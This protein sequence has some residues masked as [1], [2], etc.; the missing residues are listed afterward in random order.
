MS[1]QPLHHKYR[2]QTFA[3]LVGQE[4]IATTLSNAL[5]N[6]KIAPAYL[7]T[8]P[9]GTGKTSSARIF[10]KS[11]NCLKSEHPTPT[12]CGECPV[13]VGITNGSALDVI[14]IDAAS[15]TGVDNIREIIERA[16][17]APVQCRYKV[18]VVDECLTGDSLVITD[19]GLMRLDNP[20]IKGKKVLSFNEKSE[21]WEYKKVLRWL[22]QGTKETMTIKTHNS[23]IRCTGNHLIRT[24]QGW[25]QAK[26][27]KEGMKILSP[28]DVA[29]LFTNMEF[30]LFNFIPKDIQNQKTRLLPIDSQT[31]VTQQQLDVSP[32]VK[33]AKPTFTLE[34]KQPLLVNGSGNCKPIPSPQWHTNLAM[35]QSI[36]I[37]GQE[38]VYDIEVEDNHNFVANGLLVHNCHMLSTAAFNALLKTLEEPPNRVIFIL[39]TTDPQR[40]LPTIISRCQRF[41]YRRIPLDAM[42]KHLDKIAQN[43]NINIT[44]EALTIVA[45]IANGGLR[46]AESLL[47]QLSLLAG[48]ITVERVWDLVG[49]VAET[50][51]FVLLEAIR[52]NDSEKVL[53]QCRNLMNRGK[54]PLILMQNL[55]SFYLN[56]LIAKTAPHRNDLVAV[57][58]PT[59]EKLT[60]EAQHWEVSQILAGQQILKSSEVQIKN[61]T[62][63]RLWLEIT[64][65]GLLPSARVTQSQVVVTQT[66]SSPPPSPSQPVVKDV[67][68]PAPIA[69]K[70]FEPA[71]PI[72]ENM[73]Q[74]P[75]K[76]EPRVTGVNQ[77]NIWQTLLTQAQLLTTKAFLEQQCY[78]ISFNGNIMEIAVKNKN[79]LKIAQSKV[80][81]VEKALQ[82]ITGHTVKVEFQVKE[83][84]E[85]K[86]N[87]SVKD[88]M[89]QVPYANTPPQNITPSDINKESPKISNNISSGINYESIPIRKTEPT[90]KVNQSKSSSESHNQQNK[91]E[92][93]SP[94]FADEEVTFDTDNVNERIFKQTVN[95]FKYFFDGEIINLDNILPEQTSNLISDETDFIQEIDG[96]S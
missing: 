45:Q 71:T 17:F 26:N 84:A 27:V 77:D 52:N 33:L 22:D 75:V 3:D 67:V 7:F 60:Q 88:E 23:K 39:A 48:E 61:T 85:K 11:L 46:D 43:E 29:H 64:L 54:E 21:Q 57:T 78:L 91:Q 72:K 44:P 6:D 41:D 49:A 66:V 90:K 51:L 31:W 94:N 59:W 82:D 18:Y 80:K 95:K 63:P 86:N 1:Y 53:S 28:V 65:L 68:T 37:I 25:I 5:S 2:P 19:Q 15:N 42:V 16:Q 69:T 35:V 81:S 40:V 56:L 30:P 24:A 87:F 50:D 38:K 96:D 8:G 74:L 92:H 20:E 4:A 47:D 79:L 13:C 34:S 76:E 89:Y 70:K 10:A 32:E 73:A 14:E 55:A 36:S 58:T 93:L 12:P 62:Q 83:S 9:R